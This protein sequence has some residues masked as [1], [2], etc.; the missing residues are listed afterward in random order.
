MKL[1]RGKY[2]FN[3]KLRK[4]GNSFVTTIPKDFLTLEIEDYKNKSQKKKEKNFS[5]RRFDVKLRKVGN[6]FV[7]TIPA[8]FVERFELEEGD[9]LS[10]EIDSE[11]IKHSRSKKGGKN[12]K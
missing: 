9:F 6:S 10:L 5:K 8:D 1:E 4:V 2:K 12:V 11:E 7:V 3:S